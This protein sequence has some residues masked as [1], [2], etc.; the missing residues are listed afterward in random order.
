M[1]FSNCFEFIRGILVKIVKL[2]SFLIFR[3]TDLI[4]MLFFSFSHR[5]WNLNRIVFDRVFRFLMKVF[6]KDTVNG[7]KQAL[8]HNFSFG[9]G[10]NTF[11]AQKLT[12]YLFRFKT[13]SLLFKYSILSKKNFLVYYFKEIQYIP[14]MFSPIRFLSQTYKKKC[15]K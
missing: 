3:N 6:F 13:I 7:A 1:F 2:L 10:I 12:L 11:L 9:N 5:I 4:F 14:C 8:R 15:K